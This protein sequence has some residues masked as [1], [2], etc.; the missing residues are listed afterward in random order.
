MLKFNGNNRYFGRKMMK[1]AGFC[2]ASLIKGQVSG[3]FN[4]RVFV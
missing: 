1:E 2:R 3:A 4:R